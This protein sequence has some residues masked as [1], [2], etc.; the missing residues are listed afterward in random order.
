[1]I[2]RGSRSSFEDRCVVFDSLFGVAGMSAV[3][4]SPL[5]PCPIGIKPRVIWLEER[6]D[7]LY[8]T[9]ERYRSAQISP[10]IEWL[11]E[12]LS[13]EKQLLTEEAERSAKTCGSSS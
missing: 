12:L 3:N 7:A 1:M 8:E 4:E 13:L 10:A 11:E 5:A 2:Q 9:I 6:R